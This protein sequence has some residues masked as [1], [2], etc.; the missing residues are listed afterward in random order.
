VTTNWMFE[1]LRRDAAADLAESVVKDLEITKPPISPFLVIRS[2]KRRIKAFGDD[3]G[4]SFDGRLE[5]QRPRF[6][7]FYNTKYDV[8][9]HDGGHHPR[10]NFT[11]A[12]ELG[13]FFLA[14]HHNYLKHGG[15]PHGSRS[16]FVSD[17]NS[18]RE[19]DAFASGLL[20][21]GFLFKPRLNKGELTLDRLEVIAGEFEASL[22]S[23]VIRAVRVSD[24][25][26]AV[27]GIRNGEIAWMFPSNRLIEG[28]CY[29]GKRALESAQAQSQWR[30]F[31]AGSKERLAVEGMARHWF[32]LF[33]REDELYDA[34]VTEQYLPSQ[35][36]STLVVLLTLD[37]DDVF[38]EDAEEEDEEDKLH[39]ERFGF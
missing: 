20:L 37:E 19:A 29:P 32:Q 17:N 5:Y 9:P 33:G 12:H 27:V 14:A 39:R 2:E 15:K 4:D 36:M 13:H 30:L 25:P 8:W 24:L 10:V 26:C 23:T 35:K 6:I 1:E 38:P 18:E 7:L 34:Y 11:V 28:K 16:E 3:F 21:P 22:L 31:L